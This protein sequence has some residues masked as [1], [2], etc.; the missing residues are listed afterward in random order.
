MEPPPREFGEWIKRRHPGVG[1]VKL[2]IMKGLF[3]TDLSVGHNRLSVPAKQIVDADF[4][5][6][7]EAALLN[8]KRGE[9][10][11]VKLYGPGEGAGYTEMVLKNWELKK[12]NS[13]VLNKGWMSLVRRFPEVFQRM[14]IVQLW[15]FREAAGELAFRITKV[16][17]LPNDR[18]S[19]SGS[20]S[21]SGVKSEPGSGS[22][23]GSD[24]DG[25]GG[26]LDLEY[27]LEEGEVRPERGRP[28]VWR[29]SCPPRL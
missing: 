16:G 20:G 12:S 22:D 29:G 4:L 23:G 25:G 19:G 24:S 9:G 13:Y 14:A 27:E 2:V 17:Q 21:G 1:E 15:S 28:R 7:E 11:G 3:E 8:E 5:T 26:G 10:I 18:A 6:A